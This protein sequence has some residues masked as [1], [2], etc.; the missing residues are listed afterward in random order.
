MVPKSLCGLTAALLFTAPP[1]A[2]Q[3][4]NTTGLFVGA[5]VVFAPPAELSYRPGTYSG[6]GFSHTISPSQAKIGTTTLQGG[7]RGVGGWG[8]NRWIA[9]LA[10][11]DI[12]GGGMKYDDSEDEGSSQM[13]IFTGIRLN[14]P[15]QSKVVPYA[16]ATVGGTSVTSK[17]EVDLICGT[18]SGCHPAGSSWDGTHVGLGGGLEIGR[19]AAENGYFAWDFHA[20][21]VRATLD[22]DFGAGEK[23]KP[24]N[25]LRVSAGFVWRYPRTTPRGD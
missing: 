11:F 17:G 10:G 18:M 8:F 23:C 2:A 13:S 25:A 19:K 4:T 9:V 1:A 14:L 7:L 3:G 20:E 15:N 6:D 16:F 12:M 5:Q 24:F 21:S 22:C